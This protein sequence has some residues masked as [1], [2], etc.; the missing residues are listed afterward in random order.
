MIQR[1]VNDEVELRKGSSNH[2]TWKFSMRMSQEAKDLWEIGDGGE[3]KSATEASTD[4]DHGVGKVHL[5]RLSIGR[6]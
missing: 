3:E 5:D 1:D 2:G 6:R 4:L